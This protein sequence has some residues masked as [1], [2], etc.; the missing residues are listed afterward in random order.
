MTHQINSVAVIGAGT[1]G[2]AI[3]AHMANA[4]LPVL[5][6]DIIPNKLTPEEEARGLTLEHAT[7]RNRIVQ[8]GFERARRARPASFMS[9][10]AERLVSLANVEDD[11]DKIAQAD[12][13]IEAIIEKLDTKQA[14][15]A[16]IESTRKPASIVTSNTPTNIKKLAVR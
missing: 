2:A 6:L 5:L 3:A 10:A 11:F 4:G 15:M 9:Q 8:A 12:W 13:I 1:M 16:R 7:V 14:L